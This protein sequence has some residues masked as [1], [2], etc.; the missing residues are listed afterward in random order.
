M[1]LNV[2]AEISHFYGS[3]ER[4]V[5]A[6]GGNTSFKNEE[7]LYIKGSGTALATITPEGFVK[8][9]RKMLA[10]IWTKTY[11]EDKDK[12]EAEVLK[13]MMNA[14]CEG[15]EGK[16][17]S[18]ETL[19][20]NLFKQQ[21]VLH[22]HPTMVNGLTCAVSGKSIVEALFDNAIWIEETEP[23]YVLA[24]KCRERINEYENRTNKDADLL[25]LQN[26]G[27]FFAADDRDGIDK[28]VNEV[29]SAIDRLVTFRP[30][31]T[32]VDTYD[33]SIVDD[34]IKYIAEAYGNDP[35]VKF[36]LNKE[37]EK[38]CASKEAFKVLMEPMSPDHIVY[39]KAV[40]LFI[41][42][43]DKDS[44]KAQYAEFI[45]TYG[46]APKIAFAKGI[47]MFAVGNNIKDAA[48]VTSVW[49]DAVKISVYAQNFG[50]VR[51]MAPDMVDFIVNWEVES[52]R[53]KVA[54]NNGGN[55]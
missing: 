22:V 31:L 6:G 34:L 11:S 29:M 9:S 24:A 4:Y 26:H 47:G 15:E 50:G 43:F 41:E 14:K 2:I 55:K 51:H 49:L 17:P 37:V 20:H 16:R 10:D 48:T 21:Y 38:L 3:D 44:I 45:N 8:M 12:R 52:Y 40:P 54:L 18:V 19:L 46:Y 33:S 23:G 13:D 36:T 39:C 7:N 28:L 1:G 42:C 25:F 53:S 5:L 30:D 35:Y 32:S 27:I